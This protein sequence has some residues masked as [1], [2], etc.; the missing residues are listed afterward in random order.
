M[1]EQPSQVTM[2]T[3]YYPPARAD[4]YSIHHK[5]AVNV[6]KARVSAF[7]TFHPASVGTGTEELDGP[8]WFV[9]C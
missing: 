9:S 1:N 4:L 5:E 8:V 7:L 3:F 6:L 2:P